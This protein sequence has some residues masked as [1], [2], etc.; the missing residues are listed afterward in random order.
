[1]GHRLLVGTEVMTSKQGS[2]E[3]PLGLSEFVEHSPEKKSEEVTAMQ[4][5]PASQ[6]ISR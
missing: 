4:H 1:M 3:Y 2:I 5:L 6:V